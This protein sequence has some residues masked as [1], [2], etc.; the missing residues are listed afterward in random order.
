MSVNFFLC[1]YRFL[2]CKNF[3]NIGGTFDMFNFYL[4]LRD[5]VKDCIIATLDMADAACG[6][7]LGPLHASHVVVKNFNGTFDEGLFELEVAEKVSDVNQFADAFIGG[8]N[9]GFGRATSSH[10]LVF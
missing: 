1:E 5:F 9:F 4:F 2:F 10:G 7:V 3:C 6:L 8:V